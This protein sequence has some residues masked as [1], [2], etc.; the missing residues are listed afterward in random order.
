[1]SKLYLIG[2]SSLPY[3]KRKLEEVEEGSIVSSSEA[4]LS[5]KYEFPR[6]WLRASEKRSLTMVIGG[7]LREGNRYY[8][9]LYVVNQGQITKVYKKFK[10]WKDE[11]SWLTPAEDGWQGNVELDGH[12]VSLLICQDV[13]ST[14]WLPTRVV[15][16]PGKAIIDAK[17]ELILCPAN[18]DH[19]KTYTF[20]EQTLIF[21]GKLA[22]VKLVVVPNGYGRSMIVRYSTEDGKPRIEYL[23]KPAFAKVG[24]N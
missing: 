4:V 16:R 20:L 23:P 7:V 3:L 1:M 11:E 10:L 5:S 17:P 15:K 12:R 22:N 24:L 6:E 2:S 19:L 21:L 14:A 8:N 9:V 18:W 13:I